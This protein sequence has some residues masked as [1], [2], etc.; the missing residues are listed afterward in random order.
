MAELQHIKTQFH[1]LHAI[2]PFVMPDPTV[3]ALQPSC[4]PC[5]QC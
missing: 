3:E 5:G 2:M 1:R 4:T